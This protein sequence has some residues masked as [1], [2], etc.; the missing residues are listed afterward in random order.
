M[1]RCPT[2]GSSCSRR[3]ISRHCSPRVHCIPLILVGR[4]GLHTVN[5]PSVPAATI[6]LADRASSRF[7]GER[8][9]HLVQTWLCRYRMSKLN[10]CSSNTTDIA[11]SDRG[12]S[13]CCNYL[14]DWSVTTV[15]WYSSKLRIRRIPQTTIRHFS[16]V[17]L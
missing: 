6:S 10:C 1:R 17:A 13:S 12:T 4:F 15:N 3:N 9:H 7:A 11:P 14:R 2:I 16:L 8:V 5:V